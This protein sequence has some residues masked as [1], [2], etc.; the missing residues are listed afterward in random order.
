M[1]HQV[2]FPRPYQSWEGVDGPLLAAVDSILLPRSG[3]RVEPMMRP[4]RRIMLW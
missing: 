4:D 3:Y 1:I 2:S